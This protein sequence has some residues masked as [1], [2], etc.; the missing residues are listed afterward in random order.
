[1]NN[2]ANLVDLL[3]WRLQE[4]P[5][6]RAYTLMIDG[7]EEGSTLTYAQLDRQAR[8]IAALLQS[9]QAEGER[10]LLLFPQSLEVIAAFMGCLYAGVIA[11]PA[12]APEASRL[13]RTLPRLQAI[14]SDAGASIV[15]TT[16]GI[17]SLLGESVIEFPAMRWLASEEIDLE[18]ASDWQ[19]LHIPSDRLAYLQYTSGSTSTPK[20]VAIAHD[21]LLHHCTYLQKYCAYTPNSV[22]VTWMPYF[23][24]YGLVEGLIQP[25]YN[26][27]PC[28]V[29]SPFALIRRPFNWLNNISRYRATHS[30][31]PNFA[32]DLCVRRISAEQR[33]QLDLSNWRAAGNAA[34]PIDPKVLES[35]ARIFAACGFRPEA[36]CPAYGL[37]EATLLV[38][39][40]AITKIPSIIDLDPAALERERV[41][42]TKE[43]QKIVRR[44]V[45]CGRLVGNTKVAIV[46]P[47]TLTKCAFD[48]I[49]EIWVADPSV[50]RGYWQKQEESERTF[51]AYLA[52]TGEGPFLRT[53]DLGFIKDGELFV[54]GRI[55][56]VIIIRGSNYYPQDIEWSVQQTHPCL[57]SQNGAAFA[58]E[59]DGQEKLVIVQELER[60]YLQDLD[61]N[62]V[63]ELII[64]EVFEQYEIQV[65]AICLIKSGTLLKTSSGKIQRSASRQAFLEG[66]LETLASW[67]ATTSEIIPSFQANGNSLNRSKDKIGVKSIQKWLIALLD[68]EWKIPSKTIDLQKPFAYYGIDSVMAVNLSQELEDWLERPIEATIVW[69][70]PT[71]ESLASHLANEINSQDYSAKQKPDLNKI[72]TEEI[73][74]LLSQEIATVRQH[75]K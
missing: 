34:E 20:G 6:K 61:L 22:S 59:I 21:N 3:Q 68:R 45:G 4:E 7:K 15:L 18:L 42:E 11:I 51:R 53:G 63:F 47:H 54:T 49:G 67:S 26:G 64:R 10:V 43:E 27:T 36:F 17:I 62:E 28:Y 13:K 32:Y 30:Q 14:A 33:V 73:A 41:I 52:D 37:A 69:N 56:D 46:N 60:G 5:E 39:S 65:H 66:S 58:V 57:R 25:L 55:K 35:F 72:S 48:R 31:A 71:I 44:I 1:M 16:A 75:F 29:M 70:F 12:P 38:S 24:D 74:Q 9:Y 8:A 19:Q 2:L 40:S 23:H 50:A